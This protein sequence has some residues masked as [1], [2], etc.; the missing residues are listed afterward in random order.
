[1]PPA[2]CGGGS[3]CAE[4]TT[5]GLYEVYR[6]K[7]LLGTLIGSENIWRMERFDLKHLMRLSHTMS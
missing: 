3:Y 6:L 2:D 7:L 5:T 1:M 4:Y